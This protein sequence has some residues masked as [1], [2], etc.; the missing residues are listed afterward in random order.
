MVDLQR[1]LTVFEAAADDTGSALNALDETVRMLR[2]AAAELK[3]QLA[4]PYPEST[5]DNALLA[6]IGATA[7]QA[8][9]RLRHLAADAD[10]TPTAYISALIL[11]HP[12][13]A[14]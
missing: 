11:E 2:C 7:P 3:A 14:A 9:E 5:P 13:P 12:K 8:A 6:F 10:A 4:A 1:C